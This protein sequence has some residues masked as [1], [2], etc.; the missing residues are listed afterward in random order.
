[1]P[2][3]SNLLLIDAGSLNLLLIDAGS[4]QQFAA[5]AGAGQLANEQ[6]V[7]PA[8]RVQDVDVAQHSVVDVGRQGLGT[9][10]T[11]IQ[12]PPGRHRLGR[13]LLDEL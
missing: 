12:G 2:V 13:S 8:Q 9:G 4:L 10:R 3:L 11:R 5:V 1:M 6:E 7:V